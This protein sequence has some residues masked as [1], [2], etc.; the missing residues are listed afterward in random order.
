MSGSL[1]SVVVGDAVESASDESSL[2][3]AL[4]VRRSRTSLLEGIRALDVPN[5]ASFVDKWLVPA[6]SSRRKIVGAVQRSKRPLK[7]G[8]TLLIA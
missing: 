8:R 4:Y 1:F 2:H 6:E 7:Q 3:I 5:R